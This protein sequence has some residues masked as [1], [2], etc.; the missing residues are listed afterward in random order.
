MLT[1]NSMWP[2]SNTEMWKMNAE[3]LDES[4]SQ[5]VSMSLDS[6]LLKVVGQQK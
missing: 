5:I 3:I 6:C 2:R 4:I 1:W